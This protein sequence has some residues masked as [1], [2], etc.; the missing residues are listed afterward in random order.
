MLNA[1]VKLHRP[2]TILGETISSSRRPYSWLCL[3]LN[4]I[5]NIFFYLYLTS[6][7]DYRV[8]M[9]SYMPKYIKWNQKYAGVTLRTWSI[10]HI[11]KRIMSNLYLTMQDYNLKNQIILKQLTN[12]LGKT[13]HV[14]PWQPTAIYS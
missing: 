13:H 14:S 11:K 2:L 4:V 7:S 8:I 10:I 3:P 5:K 12:N 1:I 9:S 6:F